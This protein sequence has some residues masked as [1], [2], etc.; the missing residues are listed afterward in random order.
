MG[1]NLLTEFHENWIINVTSR[2]ST[3]KIA[4]PCFST[5]QNNFQ[6]RPRYYKNNN[7]LTK[8][9]KDWTIN[10]ILRVTIFELGSDIIGTNVLTRFHEYWT[11]NGAS[12]LLTRLFNSHI[13]KYAPPHGSHGFQQTRTIFKLVQDII[14][15]NSV[16]KKN[17]VPPKSNVCQPTRTIFKHF[18]DIIRTNLLTHTFHL[19]CIINMASRVLTI[20]PPLSARISHLTNKDIVDQMNLRKAESV[21]LVLTV[22]KEDIL[23]KNS[24]PLGGHV[25]KA[26]GTIFKLVKDITR[27]NLTKFYNDRTI[28]VASRPPGGDVFQPTGTILEL[29]QYMNGTNILT[30]FHEFRTIN[31]ASRLTEVHV[32]YRR[33]TMD[34]AGTKGDYKSST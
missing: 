26:T 2:V 13:G 7:V 9:H 16:N 17:A 21:V 22:L 31:V 4:P 18:Q 29:V 30:E 8:F 20:T 28:N 5:D 32:E 27:T 33:C 11:I 15:T 12:R 24:Q 10:V 19:H 34:D 23:I 6:N 1:T 14:R 25:F 3:S